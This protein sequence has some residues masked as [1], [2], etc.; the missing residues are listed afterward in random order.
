[1]LLRDF[2]RVEE[3]GTP[4]R[5]GVGGFSSVF[6]VQ[7]GQTVAKVSRRR[8]RR[9]GLLDRQL[10]RLRGV[11]D[12]QNAVRKEAPDPRCVPFVYTVSPMEGY[13]TVVVEDRGAGVDAFEFAN[14]HLRGVAQ[15][16]CFF[17]CVLRTCA[18]VLAAAS[19]FGHFCHNDL[20]LE[21]LMYNE[22][23]GRVTLVDFERATFVGENGE[24]ATTVKIPY[25][26]P[27]P[28]NG[29][30][31]KILVLDQSP[32][33]DLQCLVSSLWPQV[34]LRRNQGWPL[35]ARGAIGLADR[36]GAG[37][38]CRGRK[39]LPGEV[40]V[41]LDPRRDPAYHPDAVLRGLLSENYPTQITKKKTR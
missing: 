12:V 9:E 17:L 10:E 5:I 2:C 31:R 8:F 30:A 22:P 15:M 14:D 13:R 39:A 41:N 35:R 26:S 40:R 37:L 16:E 18:E 6:L 38:A 36:L 4:E 3:G 11:R 20:R 28:P 19:R 27:V 29:F 24:T 34:V 1:M 23:D 32:A 33:S 25:M 7:G 21:N